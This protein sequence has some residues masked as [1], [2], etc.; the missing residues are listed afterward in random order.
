M[1]DTNDNTLGMS[2][3]DAPEVPTAPRGMKIVAELPENLG[4][5]WED[6]RVPDFNDSEQSN[7]CWEVDFPIAQINALSQLKVNAGKAIY[8]MSRWWARRRS[9]VFRSV[10]IA[11]ATD[12]TISVTS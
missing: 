8:Q 2:W 10:L 12:N 4:K 11:A 1:N 6:C 9:S 7:T 5:A 3:T